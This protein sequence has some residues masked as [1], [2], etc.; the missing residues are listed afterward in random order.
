M[1]PVA[2]ALVAAVLACAAAV[3]TAFG[4]IW[5]PRPRASELDRG[6]AERIAAL[7]AAVAVERDRAS[8][9]PE[10]EET[11]KVAVEARRGA[12]TALAAATQ[13]REDLEQKA[14]ELQARLE[15]AERAEGAATGELGKVKEEKAKAESAVAEKTATLEEKAR[16]FEALQEERLQLQKAFATVRDE[17]A[18][19]MAQVCG[20]KTELEQQQKQA[21]EKLQ[22]LSNARESLT[23]EFKVLANDVLARHGDVFAKQNKEQIDVVLQPLREQLAEYEKGV[24]KLRE[25]SA[26]GQATISEQIRQ[27]TENSA[28]MTSE[29]TNLAQA[30]RG[31]SQTQG[32]WGEMILAS[33]L[34]RSGLR[35]GE[36]YET[37]VSRTTEEGERLRPDVIVHLPGGQ[38][39]IIDSKVSLKAFEEFVGAGT[40]EERAES[41]GRHVA[42]LRGHIKGLSSKEYQVRASSSLDY[43]VMFVPIEGALAAALQGDPGLTSFAVECNVAIATPTTLMIALRTVDSVWKIERRNSNADEIARRAGRMYDKFVSFVSD[44]TSLGGRLDQAQV[45]YRAAV[46]KLSSGSGNLV[47]QFEKLKE[48]GA[49]TGKALPP[50][51]L[52]QDEELAAD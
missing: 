21:A 26:A 1:P 25:D 47:G 52:G 14:G 39:V 20:L 43:V 10:L 18:G 49:R 17:N 28:R 3:A 38:H 42:S 19:L 36:E 13:A 37:Q 23:Q 27:L 9:L 44:L 29:T 40:D 15:S 51:L 50:A 24:Q 22:I 8:R 16:N 34:E 5:R 33:I 30:L 32:A 4:A 46:G 6:V 41:L 11:L 35:A 31:S 45:S 12:E 7:E 48:L 2:V